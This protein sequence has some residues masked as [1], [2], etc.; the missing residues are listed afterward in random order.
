VDREAT[1]D[2]PD[3]RREQPVL[4][5]AIDRAISGL[6]WRPALDFEATIAA[7]ATGHL[8]IVAASDTDAVRE[9]LDLEITTVTQ[10][11][12]AAGARWALEETDA[13]HRLPDLRQQPTGSRARP[14]ADAARKPGLAA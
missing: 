1:V 10:A 6:G 4:R 13:P 2:E 9:L 11:A 8:A 14:G 12:R 3:H 5:L 7:T